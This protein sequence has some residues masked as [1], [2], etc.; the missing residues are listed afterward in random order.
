MF[1]RYIRHLANLKFALAGIWRA[2]IL[3]S[4]KSFKM[5]LLAAT[6]L[7]GT[8]AVLGTSVPRLLLIAAAF[9][10]ALA[11]ELQN[12]ASEQLAKKFVKLGYSDPKYD[13]V[14]KSALDSAAGGVMLSGLAALL[15]WLAL[16]FWPLI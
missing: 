5:M 8:S 13:P 3:E 1:R 11:Q 14:I 7:L 15:I 9:I 2:L 4:E 12:T 16:T 6:L 10:Y